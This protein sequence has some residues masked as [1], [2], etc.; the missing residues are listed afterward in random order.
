[1]PGM[2]SIPVAEM[3]VATQFHHGGPQMFKNTSQNSLIK[4][5]VGGK[6]F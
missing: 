6:L 3:N 4:K 2:F 5:E 1:M